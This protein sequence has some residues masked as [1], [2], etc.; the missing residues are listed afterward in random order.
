MSARCQDQ[1]FASV[2]GTAKQ[3]GLCFATTAHSAVPFA[4]AV[5][6]HLARIVTSRG[7]DRKTAVTRPQIVVKV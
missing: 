4:N 6:Q 1:D 7:T 3:V 5:A 2:L